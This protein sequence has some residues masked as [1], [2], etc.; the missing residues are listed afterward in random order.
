MFTVGGE[1]P[2][3]AE[4][5]LAH[6]SVP[7]QLEVIREAI[8]PL[9]VHGVLEDIEAVFRARRPDLSD[10]G[11]EKPTHFAHL[12]GQADLADPYSA[13]VW[14]HQYKPSQNVNERWT[15]L[16]HNHRDGMVSLLLRAGFQAEERR[17]GGETPETVLAE[18]DTDWTAHYRG[19]RPQTGGYS[20]GER[21]SIH[22]D[23]IHRLSAVLPGTLSLAIR[24]PA[25]RPFSVVFKGEDGGNPEI[26]EDMAASRNSLLGDLEHGF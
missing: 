22:P 2:L 13:K 23:E 14:L 18:K 15:E 11:A 24:L 12:L 16:D 17:F 3:L 4:L 10:W 25:K 7:E 5:E 6:L 9:A 8:A 21:M 1:A 26:K 20:A 19:L